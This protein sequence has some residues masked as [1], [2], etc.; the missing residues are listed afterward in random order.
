MAQIRPNLAQPSCSA[1]SYSVLQLANLAIL[2][3]GCQYGPIWQPRS[4]GG[5]GGG[6]PLGPPPRPPSPRRRGGRGGGGGGGG[7]A[8]HL[9]PAHV[10]RLSNFGACR[11]Y[12]GRVNPRSVQ[13]LQHTTVQGLG[14]EEKTKQSFLRF[15]FFFGPPPQK[16]NV[17]D[18]KMKKLKMKNGRYLSMGI[19]GIFRSSTWLE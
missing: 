2:A 4:W 8:S 17:V 7:G 9:R 1:P 6:P 5:G 18:E 16:I 12:Q 19:E 10:R 11:G 14:E 3:I 15:F 13:P